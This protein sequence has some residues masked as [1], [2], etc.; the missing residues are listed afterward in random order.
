MGIPSQPTTNISLGP[1]L[2]PTNRSIS[3]EFGDSSP[4]ALGEFYR[5]SPLVAEHPANFNIP[6]TVGGERSF[7]QYNGSSIVY[8]YRITANT[9]NLNLYD[10]ATSLSRQVGQPR[11]QG[12]VNNERYVNGAGNIGIEFQL[13]ANVEKPI[14]SPIGFLAIG[15]AS[16]TQAAITTGTGWDPD[17][18]LYI[19][20]E[21]AIHAAGGSG[22]NGGLGGTNPG[23][24]GIVLAQP[25]Q[26][27]GTAIDAQRPITIDN[28][29]AS[30][31]PAQLNSISISLDYQTPTSVAAGRGDIYAGGGG[32]GG[33]TG[34]AYPGGPPQGAPLAGGGGGGGASAATFTSGS[35]PFYPQYIPAWQQVAAPGLGGSSPRPYTVD[36]QPGNGKPGWALDPPAPVPVGLGGRGEMV[37]PPSPLP[38]TRGG[39]G[40]VGGNNGVTGNAGHGPPLAPNPSFNPPGNGTA[41]QKVGTTPDPGGLG[42]AVGFAVV[43]PGPSTQPSPVTVTFINRPWYGSLPVPQGGPLRYGGVVD[44]QLQPGYVIVQYPS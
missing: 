31:P 39:N 37:G 33:G 1:T 22:G 25:G 40:G 19:I 29:G 13:P 5:G 2:G 11:S 41:G 6:A 43:R 30:S 16:R 24:V 23:H 18:A 34:F 26:S 20:N 38:T 27:G 15:T 17:V 7:S 44:G 28:R 21:A 32:G 8:R 35:S 36:G 9:Q 10:Y 42:G 4:H 14:P 12:F 3:N